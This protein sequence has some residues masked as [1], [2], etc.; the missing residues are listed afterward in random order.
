MKATE[1][2]RLY[3]RNCLLIKYLFFPSSVIRSSKEK[4]F[5]FGCCCFSC[6][7]AFLRDFSFIQLFGCRR[8]GHHERLFFCF[9]FIGSVTDTSRW[10]LS[11]TSWITT[12]KIP[13]SNCTTSRS[14]SKKIMAIRHE[15]TPHCWTRAPSNGLERILTSNQATSKERNRPGWKTASGPAVDSIY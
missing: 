9:L 4:H 15:T 6:L 10:W 13:A 14:S 3:K 2:V 11:S 7:K 5:L 12:A 8:W 1:R